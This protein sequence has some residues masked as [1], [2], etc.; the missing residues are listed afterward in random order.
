MKWTMMGQMAI[1]ITLPGFNDLGRLVTPIFPLID[2]F[3]YR[4]ST[5]CEK[6]EEILSTRSLISRKMHHQTPFFLVTCIHAHLSIW[7]FSN[8]SWRVK[9]CGSVVNIWN[10]LRNRPTATKYELDRL[11][12]LTHRRYVK[13]KN[14]VDHAELRALIFQ[15]AQFSTRVISETK[16]VTSNC[17]RN[18]Y[19]R[20]SLFD[21]S[22]N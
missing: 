9:F 8:A 7:R 10:Y 12:P 19:T 20:N 22:K 2:H 21:F 16:S 13:L 18:I 5:F 4:F 15:L 17:F 14:P 6:N 1:A 3:I 11:P